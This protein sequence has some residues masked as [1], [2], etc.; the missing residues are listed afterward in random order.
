[1]KLRTSY[2]NASVLR[3]DLTRYA[4]VW[5]LYTVLWVL[6]V[7]LSLG[8]LDDSLTAARHWSDMFSA[9]ALL[10]LAYGGLTAALLL[11]DLFN[12][13][14]CNALHAMPMRR[15]GWLLTHSAAGILFAL[16]PYGITTV[17]LVFLLGGLRFLAFWWFA[18]AMLSYLFFF[19]TAIFS[20]IC[21]GNRLGMG[22]V[23]F[24][25]HFFFLLVYAVFYLL[26]QPLLFG[27]VLDMEHVVHPL[28]PT[29][30]LSEL[31]FV[32]YQWKD[33]QWE[34]LQ[35][36]WF[37]QLG[38]TGIGILAWIASFF[39]YRRRKLE[40]S[41]DFVAFKPVAPVFLGFY[42]L[43]VGC[44]LY[45]FPDIFGIGDSNYIFLVLGIL[46]GYFTG[47]M[48]LERTLRVFRPRA[49]AGLALLAMLLAGTMAL[50]WLDP[51]R[52]TYYMPE[53]EDITGMRIYSFEDEHRFR[54][55]EGQDFLF[56]Q[57][58]DIQVL[59]QL[60]N[61]M[62]QDRSSKK[63]VADPCN[64]TV[65]YFLTSGSTCTRHYTVDPAT[66]LGQ[67]LGLRL[68]DYRHVF[69]T[70]NLEEYASHIYSAQISTYDEKLIEKISLFSEGKE[71]YEFALEEIPQLLSAI[72]A[73]CDAGCMTQDWSFHDDY[74]DYC[75]LELEVYPNGL[76]QELYFTQLRI[77]ED[78]A[79][80]IG[81]LN[82][83][84]N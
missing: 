33:A 6:I 70:E 4:P 38:C 32:N 71:Q 17:L 23:Y 5:V 43:G 73:D 45:I 41:G 80:T 16:I 35:G 14:M 79:N 42:T 60:H 2:F 83:L 36:D 7:Y 8:H 74:E 47:K 18:L 57:P 28:V 19:G 69:L 62:I 30:L 77:S 52:V 39:L 68:S 48:F 20:G 51:L 72:K 27:I 13:R 66:E 84:A 64:I 76:D 31:Q 54:Y 78:C 26:Y 56:T 9:M 59:Q 82:S 67:D 40:A 49:F 22:A 1:M 75:W 53:E 44:V 11:G 34:F 61:Q 37:Y 15:E 55:G 81:Y 25:I 29:L 12:P 24:I 21:A 50:T 3:K 58:E 65:E 63:Y 10:N 46:I